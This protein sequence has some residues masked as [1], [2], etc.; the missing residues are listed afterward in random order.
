MYVIYTRPYKEVK[1]SIIEII[2]EIYFVLFLLSL[3]FL[4]EEKDWNSAKTSLYNIFI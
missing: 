4:N 3:I 1:S 2:N